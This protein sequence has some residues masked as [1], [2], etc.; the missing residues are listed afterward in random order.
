MLGGGI[1]LAV[2][3]CAALHNFDGL[4]VDSVNNPIEVV[5]AAAPITCAGMGAFFTNVIF[6]SFI[7]WLCPFIK[8]GSTA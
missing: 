3:V 5:N 2:I 8:L 7:N 4:A 6:A 1:A